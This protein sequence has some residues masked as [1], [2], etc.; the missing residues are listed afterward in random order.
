M[1]II[2]EYNVS[3]EDLAGLALVTYKIPDL[4]NEEKKAALPPSRHK[5]LAAAILQGCAQLEDPLAVTQILTAVYLAGTSND[6]TIREFASHFPQ[7][8]V[9][10]CQDALLTLGAKAA[11]IELGPEV[12]TLKGLFLERDGKTDE[13]ENAYTEAVQ[14]CHFKFNPRSNHPMQFPLIKPWNA[15]GQLLKTSP[16]PGRREQ[17][18]SY[19]KKGADEGDDP[20]S[21]L[22]LAALEK[23]GSLDWLKYTSK[24][25][26]SGHRDAMVDLSEFYKKA[27]ESESP[28][29]A[30]SAMRKA[31]GW[32]LKW[33]GNSTVRL[34]AEWRR[35][36]A[37][38][39]HKPSLLKLA[40]YY[41]SVGDLEGEKQCLRELAEPPSK[42][43]VVEEWPQLAQLGRQ[44]LA[45]IR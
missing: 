21:C 42:A 45:G 2:A 29:L 31:L 24:V 16:D 8:V 7:A 41:K 37:N 14:R 15:L 23:R 22:E 38:M 11:K 36:A 12:L 10:K 4:K 9:A 1:L 17:A 28:V 13:A 40:D 35:A 34:A 32:L 26:A 27:S 44:R 43:G 39:G 33:K 18:K 6:A 30:D 5:P 20:L 19:F 3:V 25:A